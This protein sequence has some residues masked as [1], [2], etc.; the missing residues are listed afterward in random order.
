MTLDPVAV[1]SYIVA[2]SLALS[3]LFSAA[4]PIW[5]KLPRWLSVAI[6][7]LV[8][9]LPL[10]AQYFGH[11]ATTGSLSTALVTSLALLLPGIT[12]AELTPAQVTQMKVN[13]LKSA[14]KDTSDAVQATKDAHA[15]PVGEGAPMPGVTGTATVAVT[16]PKA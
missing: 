13:A 11:V 6:P 1:A 12:E 3:K 14:A 10:V 5:K 4:Q 16:P 8:L 9:D 2:G 7:V 15:M